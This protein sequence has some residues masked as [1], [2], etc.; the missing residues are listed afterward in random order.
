MQVGTGIAPSGI[1]TSPDG[2][3]WTTHSTPLNQFW[4]AIAFGNGTFVAVDFN[5]DTKQVLTSNS[6]SIDLPVSAN[7]GVVSIGS[8]AFDGSTSGFFVGSSSGTDLAVN[9]ISGYAGNLADLQVAGVSKFNVTGAGLVG[10]GTTTPTV[11]LEVAGQGLFSKGTLASWVTR[12]APNP[13]QWT[14]VTYGNGL[15]VAVAQ[16]GTAAQQIMTSPDGITWTARTSP[17]AQAWQHK[18]QQV[19]EHGQAL[20]IT[21]TSTSL[22]QLL[23]MVL[24]RMM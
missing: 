23:P 10:I 11:S 5:G 20:H 24:L 2:I 3:T 6:P 1:A 14:S 17:N 19:H 21:Q 4:D 12:T 18:L 15:Y 9:E 8:G 22:L 7:Y 13:Q 16:N